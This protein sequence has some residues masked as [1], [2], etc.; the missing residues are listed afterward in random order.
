[1]MHLVLEQRLYDFFIHQPTASNKLR[2]IQVL[3]GL[4][5][6]TTLHLMRYKLIAFGV[7]FRFKFGSKK[8]VFSNVLI[9]SSGYGYFFSVCWTSCQQQKIWKR[10][11]TFLSKGKHKTCRKT[12]I[13]SFVCSV[14]WASRQIPGRRL[15]DLTSIFIPCS[16]Y[17]VV[18]LGVFL[19]LS[20]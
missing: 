17:C 5:T 11:K 10:G 16:R 9:L 4:C 19:Q 20:Q 12:R 14:V 3:N 6:A 2:K 8:I 18:E 13:A 7:C 1:M 15:H